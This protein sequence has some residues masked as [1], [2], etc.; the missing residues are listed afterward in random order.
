MLKSSTIRVRICSVD[1]NKIKT[2]L[3][4]MPVL[5]VVVMEL[6]RESFLMEII[7]SY[8]P[9]ILVIFVGYMFCLSISL[10]KRFRVPLLVIFLLNAIVGGLFMYQVWVFYSPHF[11]FA[12]EQNQPIKL[13]SININAANESYDAIREFFYD[14]KPD[15]IVFL[16]FQQNQYEALNESLLAD[17]K[18]T[19]YDPEVKEK[20]AVIFS[21]VPLSDVD[22]EIGF[23]KATVEV[24]GSEVVLYGVH[25]TAPV[26]RDYFY[27]RN[28][29]LKNLAYD[30]VNTKVNMVV[31]GDFNLTPWSYYYD[32]FIADSALVDTTRAHRFFTWGAYGL[33]IM[34]LHIDHLLVNDIAFVT[35]PEVVDFPGS[36]HDAIVIYINVL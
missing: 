36:D 29:I 32:V 31:T 28:T 33:P 2:I 26:T 21:K 12:Q 20:Y 9:Q 22:D 24:N 23:T 16:E 19:N 5:L 34:Q 25:A 17:F 3:F 35:T 15:V 30:V 14:Q 6:L 18:Y 27:Q 13:V 10:C 8:M 1:N 4:L 7:V 11:N